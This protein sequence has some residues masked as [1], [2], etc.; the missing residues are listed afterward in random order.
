[1][2][3]GSWM[4]VQTNTAPTVESHHTTSAISEPWIILLPGRILHPPDYAIALFI[5]PCVH[6]FHCTKQFIWQFMLN[7]GYREDNIVSVWERETTQQ[8]SFICAMTG[9]QRIIPH[10]AFT[11]PSRKA[12]CE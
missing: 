11:C 9:I 3:D 1:M 2:L 10:P 12:L 4:I 7:L 5:P 8:V 6:R